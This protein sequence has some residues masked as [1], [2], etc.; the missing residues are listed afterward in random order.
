MGQLRT[1]NKRHK[2]AIVALQN[3]SN[4]AGEAPA[5]KTVPVTGTAG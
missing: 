1:A 4:S 5:A 2:R 3:R